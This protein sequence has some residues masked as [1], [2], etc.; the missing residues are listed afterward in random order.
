M[1]SLTRIAGGLLL[2]ALALAPRAAHAAVTGTIEG[3]VT[4]QATGKKLAGVTVTVTSPALQGEQTEFTDAGGHYIITELPPGEYMVRFY[5]SNIH[6]ERP[7]VFVPGRQDALGQRRH[8][9]AEGGGQDLPHHREG[10]DRRRRQ[11]AEADRGHERVRAQHAGAAAAPTT[12]SSRSRPG[13][14]TDA[15]RR[16]VQRRHR[17]RE[18]LPHRRREHDQPGLRP[19]RHAAH[20]RV[21]RR[22]R[23]HHRRLQRRVRPRH[24]RRR[25]R[26]HQ[27]GLEPVPRRHVVLRH[28]VPARPA[29]SSRARAKRSRRKTKTKY[30][31]DFGF[32][33]GGP[34]VKDKVWFYV[35]FAP[36]FTTIETARSLRTR[37]AN[38]MPA[39]YDAGAYAGDLDPN[40]TCPAG[41]D[42]RSATRR[43]SPAGLHHQ[44]PR[45]L[46][47]QALQDRQPPLQLDRQAQLPAQPE[48]QLGPAVHRQPADDVGPLRQ[49]NGADS[50]PPRLDASTTRTTPRC[51]SSRSSPIAACSS[52]S[53]PATTT[54]T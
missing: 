20:P 22:D 39:G 41:L 52:T 40:V 3:T 13:A 31:F 26:H 23:D 54:T 6:V 42:K 5:F 19:P 17:P 50:D 45:R 8:S 14:A 7:G 25:Q 10:A 35:G 24:R 32:D 1:R 27:V 48:Q 38:N 36:T 21:H 18:Q 44:R 46:V 11:H 51:T 37:T 28:A 34:I 9:D 47:H 30:G 2:L 15:R 16:L 33:L 49:L 4:D 43:A 53:S 29:R 12:R